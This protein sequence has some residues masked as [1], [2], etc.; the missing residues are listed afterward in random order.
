M[1][2]T[3]SLQTCA[4]AEHGHKMLRRSNSNGTNATHRVF[5]SSGVVNLVAPPASSAHKGPPSIPSG[6]A[7]AVGLTEML[8]ADP[9]RGQVLRDS[10]G[11]VCDS[12]YE[13]SLDACSLLLNSAGD[14]TVVRSSLGVVAELAIVTGIMELPRQCDI[15][16]SVLCKY[17]VRSWRQADILFLPSFLYPIASRCTCRSQCG[18]DKKC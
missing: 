8:R 6:A 11:R 2:L 4:C 5:L 13:S 14:A 17:T 18:T 1:L 9:A 7:T 15:I 10:V 12:V 16:T 3:V